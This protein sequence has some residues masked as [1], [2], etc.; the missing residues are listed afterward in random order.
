MTCMLHMPIPISFRPS[1]KGVIIAFHCC[2]I[3]LTF[4]GQKFGGSHGDQFGFCPN[5]RNKCSSAN[6]GDCQSVC[7]DVYH[8][9]HGWNVCLK[10]FTDNFNEVKRRVYTS[11]LETY[12]LAR[13]RIGVLELFERPNIVPAKLVL[14]FLYCGLF[15]VTRCDNSLGTVASGLFYPVATLGFGI[16]CIRR[17]GE[18]WVPIGSFGRLQFDSKHE[19]RSGFIWCSHRYH[20]CILPVPIPDAAQQESLRLLRSFWQVPCMQS[21]W[22]MLAEIVLCAYCSWQSETRGTST[23]SSCDP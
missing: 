2:K 15:S 5:I 1:V 12:I 22:S 19:P 17:P 6:A 16:L 3:F 4:H 21:S 8:R 20:K 13:I 23:R 10:D 7:R 18:H 11:S 9:S 14:L